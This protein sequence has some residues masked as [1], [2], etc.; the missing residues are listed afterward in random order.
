MV[1][2]VLDNAAKDIIVYLVD[3]DRGMVCATSQWLSLSGLKVRAF[4]DPSALIKVIK[5]NQPCV[6]VSDVRMPGIDG[7][8]LMKL[9]RGKDKRIPVIL[10]TG[11]GDIPLAVEAMKLGAFE[12]LSK[13]FSPEKL[14]DVT[15]Q[16]QQFWQEVS[17][18]TG[19]Q[20]QSDETMKAVEVTTDLTEFEEDDTAGNLTDQVDEFEKDLIASA[21]K[22]HR[23][24]IPKVIEELDV[25]RRTLNAKM[26]KYGIVRANYR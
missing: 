25:P 7:I 8:E 11:H 14:L 1:E 18:H 9:I 21:M 12:F 5:P 17:D 24:V 26:K 22:K 2:A 19:H 13:P 10:I 20:K 16:A 23:G 6:V 15:R 4:A 3:D